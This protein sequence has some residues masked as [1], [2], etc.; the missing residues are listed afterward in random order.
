MPVGYQVNGARRYIEPVLRAS[1]RSPKLGIPFKTGEAGKLSL[2]SYSKDPETGDVTWYQ[3]HEGDVIMNGP[4]EVLGFDAGQAID[5]GL[6]IGEA[7]TEEELGIL[8]NQ[9]GWREVGTGRELH[10]KWN[11]LVKRCQKSIQ[12][13][14]KEFGELGDDEQSLRKK[15]KIVEQWLRWYRD[16]ANVPT[17][18]GFYSRAQLKQMLIMMREQLREMQEDG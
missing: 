13:S 8:L 14:M 10:E 5:C 12:F 2:L 6:A 9:G 7:D 1:G 15:I 3:S 4:G 11:D 17:A 18:M 16:A